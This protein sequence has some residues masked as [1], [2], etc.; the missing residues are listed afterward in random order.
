VDAHTVN[1]LLAALERDGIVLLPDLLSAEQLAGM[2][3][4]FDCKLQRMRWNDVDGYEKTER[5]RH[6]VEDVLAL[7]QGFVDAALHPIVKSV[8]RA[9]VGVGYELVEAKGWQSLPTRR[10]FHGWHGDAWYDQGKVA[11]IPR[12]VKLGIY[13][14]EVNSGFFQYIKG[15]HRKQHPRQIRNEEMRSVVASEVLDVRGPAG[16]AFLFDTSGIHR[17]SVPILERRWA[18]FL[19]YHDP[20][21]PLQTEDVDQYRYH[22]LLLNAAFLGGLSDEDRRVLGF[23]N[24]KNYTRNFVAQSRHPRM[25]RAFQQVHAALLLLDNLQERVAARLTRMRGA[26][27]KDSK[28]GLGAGGVTPAGA[29]DDG[30]A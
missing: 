22:P 15:S 26:R 24:K 27:T 8:L 17:Q 28:P 6:M 23:G 5:H 1:D 2:R 9:Y 3:A 7:D 18:V 25:H 30:S 20:G 29:Q 14:T 10:D 11:S 4:A 13:L 21:V 19:N 12:E 16:C